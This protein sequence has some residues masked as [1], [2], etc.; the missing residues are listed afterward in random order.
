MVGLDQIPILRVKRR[1]SRFY[2]RFKLWIFILL[3]V[4]VIGFLST[5]IKIIWDVIKG[6][7]MVLWPVLDNPVG[8]VVLV[9]VVLAG[10]AWFAW[11]RFSAK[12]RSLVGFH[13][14]DRFLD[15]IN[16]MVM[17]RNRAAPQVRRGRMLA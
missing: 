3:F 8:R 14:L 2:K 10:I 15:G 1:L 7:G 16:H 17:G 13:A 11:W 12:L 9:T 4:I 6:I 5:P